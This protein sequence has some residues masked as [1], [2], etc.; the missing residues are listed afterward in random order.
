MKNIL[1]VCTGNSCRSQMAEGF[2]KA[3]AN[4]RFIISSAGTCPIGVHPMTIQTMK[5]AG[6]DISD[7]K[8]RM[9]DKKMMAECNYFITLCGSA[10]DSCPKPPA[11]VKQFS[12]GYR[13]P[14]YFVYIGRSA[15]ARIRAGQG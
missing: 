3:L 11:G 4:G 6:I 8:S 14:G 5:E 13:K 7:H 2:G 12:L 1:F 15:S 10:R 9:L